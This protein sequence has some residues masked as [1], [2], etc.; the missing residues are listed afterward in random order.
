LRPVVDTPSGVL[1]PRD[2]HAL[3]P[4]DLQAE[5]LALGLELRDSEG[6]QVVLVVAVLLVV[7]VRAADDVVVL[8]GLG[9][10]VILVV[11][12][13]LRLLRF[14]LFFLFV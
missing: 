14:T 4:G 1:E 3:R 7:V 2:E 9:R 5:G 10:V 12:V 8:L 6:R 11:V 13:G